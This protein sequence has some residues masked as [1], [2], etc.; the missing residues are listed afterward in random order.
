MAAISCNL[1]ITDC[2]TVVMLLAFCPGNHVDPASIPI[3]FC[4][5]I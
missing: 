3:S 1:P 2:N 4:P 5:H